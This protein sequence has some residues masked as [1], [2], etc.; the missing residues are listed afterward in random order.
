MYVKS[1]GGMSDT[2]VHTTATALGTFYKYKVVGYN[3]VQ[4][5]HKNQKQDSSG[6]NMI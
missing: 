6:Y 3:Y 4:L 2:T 5:L 1:F